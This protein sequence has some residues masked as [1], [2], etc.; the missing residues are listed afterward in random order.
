MIDRKIG[1]S[2]SLQRTI[3]MSEVEVK[4]CAPKS[5]I[6]RSGSHDVGGD[7][8][9]RISGAGEGDLTSSQVT[10]NADDDDAPFSFKVMVVKV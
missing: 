4:G 10:D 5:F 7:W 2:Q 9:L 3:P 1:F 6:S 8:G